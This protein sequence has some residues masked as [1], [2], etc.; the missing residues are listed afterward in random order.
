MRYPMHACGGT[1]QA[2]A[3]GSVRTVCLWRGG[4]MGV[5][6]GPARTR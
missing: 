3:P 1:V 6:V 2:R 4:G 5:L